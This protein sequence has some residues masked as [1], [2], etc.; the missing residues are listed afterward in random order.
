MY[1]KLA[2][3]VAASMAAFV[4]A[5]PGYPTPGSI[6]NSCDSGKVQCCTSIF[7]LLLHNPMT[8]SL[9][10]ATLFS[11][12]TALPLNR[13]LARFLAFWLF[14]PTLMPLQ[15]LVLPAAHLPLLVSRA[16]AGTFTS[17]GRR[18]I[19]SLTSFTSALRNPFAALTTA[20]VCALIQ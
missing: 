6:N 9:I 14:L 2:L 19:T 7:P 3:F 17:L 1:S 16:A 20:S 4:A 10:Q 13:Q 12:L 5:A 11:L 18:D 15:M 8:H